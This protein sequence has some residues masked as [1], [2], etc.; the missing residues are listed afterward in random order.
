MLTPSPRLL[1]YTCLRIRRFLFAQAEGKLNKLYKNPLPL[2]GKT[3]VTKVRGMAKRAAIILSGGRSE[4]FQSAQDSWQDKALVELFGKPLLVHSVENVGQVVDEIVLC[5]NDEKRKAKYSE[6]LK[7]YNLE[8]VRLVVDEQCD[9]LRGPLVGILTGLI[10]AKAD[11]CFTLP[12]D[13]PMLQPSVINYLFDSMKDT[14]AVVPMWSNGRLETLTMVLKKAD[15][16]E[17][18]KTLCQLKRPRSDDIIRGALKILLVSI[19]K[20]LAPL[21]PA[22]KSF[23][24]INSPTDLAR[25][26]PR[27]AQGPITES[28]RLNL[29]NL[30]LPELHQLQNAS[31]LFNEGKFFEAS[32]AFSSCAARLETVCS[33]F[34]AAISRENEGKSLL[35]LPK[36][37]MQQACRAKEALA[38]ACSNYELEAEIYDGTRGIFLAERARSNLEWCS[39]QQVRC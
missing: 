7:R 2:N 31:V 34:W 13:M 1:C 14:R 36:Q 24:N 25:L 22:L 30:S 33:C 15:V 39:A 29:G 4:R 16:L 12:S 21:D 10:A 20:E 17:I 18:A 6:V 26:Q 38:K 37:Q 23:I 35:K 5:V 28:L 32:N 11:Y 9:Q 19:V 8:D 27:Q 3:A